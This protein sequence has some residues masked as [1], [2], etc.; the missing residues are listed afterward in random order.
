MTA[1]VTSPAWNDGIFYIGLFVVALG[2]APFV[3]VLL[4]W[5]LDRLATMREQRRLRRVI[6]GATIVVPR[7]R[8][9][10]SRS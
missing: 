8:R 1:L 9:A 5:L 2:V 7:Q 3:E 6:P 4:D 10:G